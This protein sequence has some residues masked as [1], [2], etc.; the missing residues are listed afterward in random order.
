M[1]THQALGG[2]DVTMPKCEIVDHLCSRSSG[3]GLTLSS[4]QVHPPLRMISTM[5]GDNT[6]NGR[7]HGQRAATFSPIQCPHNQCVGL[8]GVWNS[9]G[10]I[11]L[12]CE[13]G[14]PIY[15]ALLKSGA[16][17][18]NWLRLRSWRVVKE[19]LD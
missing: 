17:T 12:Q 8:S 19:S 6:G 7:R 10:N 5:S 9:R 16:A 15:M 3:S 4:Q 1:N 11:G 2:I 18:I 14:Y 13:A